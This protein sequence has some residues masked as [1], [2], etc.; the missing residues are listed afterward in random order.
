MSDIRFFYARILLVAGLTAGSTVSPATTANYAEMATAVASMAADMAA[1]HYALKGNAKAAAGLKSLTDGLSLG[2]KG[3]FFYNNIRAQEGLAAWQWDR[4]DSVVNGLIMGRDV[5]RLGQ[6][7]YEFAQAFKDVDQQTLNEAS[8][9]A[10]E[11]LQSP[12]ALAAAGLAPEEVGATSDSDSEQSDLED[13]TQA[14]ERHRQQDRVIYLQRVIVLPL[15]KG[16]SALAIA[17]TQNY[18][19]SFSSNQARFTATAAHAF[20]RLVEEYVELKKD[21]WLKKPVVI[22]MAANLVWLAYEAHQYELELARQKGETRNGVCEQCHQ[23]RPL[24][25]LGCG[26]ARRCADCLG[27][28]VRGHDVAQLHRIGCDALGCNHRMTRNEVAGVTGNNPALMRNYDE[29]TYRQLYAGFEIRPAAARPPRPVAGPI[30]PTPRRAGQCNI[31]LDGE[32]QQLQ[33]LACNH[34]YC[35][36]CMNQ[37]VQTQFTDNRAQMD[38]TRCPECAHHFTRDEIGNAVQGNAQ[39]QRIV[40]AFDDAAYERANPQAAVLDP[41]MR[42]MIDR[43]EARI[44]PQCR[45][46]VQRNGGCNH[47]TCR[48]GAAFCYVCGQGYVG[49]QY[50]HPG[51]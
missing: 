17:C 21:S 4:R 51:C 38:H 35:N 44:C 7:L 39:H 42:A 24:R 1:N 12:E 23:N 36:G 30:Q 29:A 18:T 45:N 37:H 25:I 28:Q 16:L 11:I 41:E 8:S 40:Q 2:N 48:C 22:A 46:G 50:Y 15:F 3:L 13:D 19:T 9:L 26:H 5:T 14:E 6:H 10:E 34:A 27:A 47:M 20:S 49:G 43:G 32:E 33:V 31:C